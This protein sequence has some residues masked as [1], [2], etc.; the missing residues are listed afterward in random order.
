MKYIILIIFNVYY[1]NKSNT[2]IFVL[3]LIFKIINNED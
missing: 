2:H 1:L 3:F